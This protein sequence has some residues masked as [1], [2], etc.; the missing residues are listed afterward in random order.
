M[1]LMQAHVPR[2]PEVRRL[3]GWAAALARALRHLC[4]FVGVAAFLMLLL[5]FT[6]VPFDAH[7]WLGT[8]GGLCSGP[9]DAIVVLGGSGMPSGPELMRCHVAAQLARE[10][11]S[12]SVV[13]LLPQDTALAKAMVH[14]LGLKGVPSAHI[15][16]VLHGRNTREQAVDLAQAMPGMKNRRM[17]LVTAPENMYRSLLTFRKLGFSQV[18]GAPAFDHALFSDLAYDHLGIGGRG[19]LPDLS[20]STGLRYNFW[21]YLKLEITC[22]REYAAMAYY[23]LN[24][25]T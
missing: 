4:M 23:R 3:L 18:A 5:A 13:L 16:W 11:T 22:L 8:A 1:P 7:R 6:R 25:W 20:S 9:Q 10:S 12:A 21:N 17:A 15:T 2:P 19:Y 24:G 14:E